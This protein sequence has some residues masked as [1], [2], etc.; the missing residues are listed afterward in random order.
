MIVCLCK[1]VSERHVQT[2][3]RDGARTRK[4][5]TRACQAGGGCG[6]CHGSIRQLLAE[7]Q[8]AE[9]REFSRATRTQQH[10]DDTGRQLLEGDLAGV[11]L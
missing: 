11:S 5:V 2:A 3:I 9:R 4:Q 6:A 8:V 10:G 7:A 1:G